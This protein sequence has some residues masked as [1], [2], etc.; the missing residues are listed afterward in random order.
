MRFISFREFLLNC[1]WDCAKNGLVRLLDQS[2][3]QTIAEPLKSINRKLDQL[4]QGKNKLCLNVL[5]KRK[6]SDII[7]EDV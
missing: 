5:P 3:L 2:D 4:E 7:K 1:V 6:M